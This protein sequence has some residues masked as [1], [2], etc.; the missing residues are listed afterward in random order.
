M[1]PPFE[2]KSCVRRCGGRGAR[3]ARGLRTFG[4]RHPGL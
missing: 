2:V 3:C 1:H 4:A